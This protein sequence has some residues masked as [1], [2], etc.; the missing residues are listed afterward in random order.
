MDGD[1]QVGVS[2]IFSSI[3][4]SA[5]GKEIRF[6]EGLVPVN[7]RF[8]DIHLA[9]SDN[10]PDLAGIDSFFTGNFVPEPNTA[11]LLALGMVWLTRWY[12][13]AITGCCRRV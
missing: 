7:G 11:A 9:M 2:D 3:A 10:P 1:G 8:T 6:E 13:L 5:D 4:V 12:R